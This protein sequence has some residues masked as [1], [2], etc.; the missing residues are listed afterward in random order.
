MPA[1]DDPHCPTPREH[2]LPG[3]DLAVSSHWLHGVRDATVVPA[4][5]RPLYDLL[6]DILG[7]EHVPDTMPAR[8]AAACEDLVDV[9]QTTRSTNRG[10]G[11]VA[12][13]HYGLSYCQRVTAAI[14]T[15]RDRPPLRLAAVGCSSSKHDSDQPMPAK[16]RYR[17]AYWTCKRRY[18]D[19][20]ADDW[21]IISAQY[22]LLHPETEIP[23]YERTVDDL[24]GVPVDANQRLPSGHPVETLLDQ[25]ALQVYHGLSDW[26][27]SVAAGVDPRDVELD[28]LLGKRYKRPLQERGVFDRL[29][30]PRRAVRAVPLPRR[31]A[32]P[33]RQRQPD[34]LAHRPGRSGY[35]H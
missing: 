5:D 32:S 12:G 3:G 34:G 28:V 1:T 30:S 19:H 6:M 17:R 8:L 29:P 27:A 31:R 26:L 4:E 11:S 14:E 16:D 35:R 13:H 10:T 18:G 2:E 15:Y 23:Y 9:R 21:R 20:V 22:D 25:W 24:A 33:G 7:D